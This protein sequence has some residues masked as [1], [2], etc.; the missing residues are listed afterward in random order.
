MLTTLLRHLDYDKFEVGLLSIVDTGVHKASLPPQVK[1]YS[2]L[3]PS[4]Q[5]ALWY[6]LKYKLVH[7]LLPMSV[8]HRWIVPKGYDTEIAF[9]EGFATK[10]VAAAPSTTRRIA[11]VHIDLKSNHWIADVYKS[12]ELERRSYGRFDEICCVS[13]IVKK[14]VD[15][16]Y[17]AESKTRVVYNPVDTDE[18][19][20]KAREEV[21]DMDCSKPAGRVRL[22]S[23][24][25]FESQK[26]FDRLVRIVERL[27]AEGRDVE[28]WLL[29]DGTQRAQLK[30]YVEQ[31]GLADRILMP[32]FKP[33]P[34]KYMAQCDLFVCSSVAEGYSTAVSEA[35][36]LGLGVVTTDC[37]GM[38]EML[39]DNEFGIVTE[40]SEEALARALSDVLNGGLAAELKAKAMRRKGL[41]DINKSMA[42]IEDILKH[43]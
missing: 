43:G 3:S 19:L 18:I 23:V 7:N 28:L 35:L 42:V 31:R 40:N 26:A 5:R 4:G 10:L 33:N 1:Y 36:I 8:V 11:W 38:R 13:G 17:G 12:P 22:C 39:G 2:A 16:L 34:Y 29:G 15:E 32:G 30:R 6:R 14:S 21:D 9:V 20:A 37:S 27:I 41:F 25:R 24:G